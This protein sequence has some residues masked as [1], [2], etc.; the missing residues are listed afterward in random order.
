MEQATD[1]EG[2]ALLNA[3][4]QP[5][6]SLLCP[7]VDVMQADNDLAFTNDYAKCGV[8]PK[9]LHQPFMAKLQQW[10]HST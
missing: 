6:H 10:A 2:L 1:G 3:I 5:G 9:E 8:V 4:T 7:L